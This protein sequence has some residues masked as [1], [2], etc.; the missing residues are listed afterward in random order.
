MT[1]FTRRLEE[2]VLQL[3]IENGALHAKVAEIEKSR[4]IAQNN[5]EWARLRMNQI[6]EERSA[7][8]YRVANIQ[9]PAMAIERSGRESMAETKPLLDEIMKNITFDDVGDEVARKLGVD[10]EG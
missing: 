2:L 6:E 8:F 9:L 4:A 10:H 5:F 1:M 7:L 3:R